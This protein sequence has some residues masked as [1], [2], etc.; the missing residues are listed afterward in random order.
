MLSSSQRKLGYRD[1]VFNRKTKLFYEQ[2]AGDNY[3]VVDFTGG[4]DS[5]EATAVTTADVLLSNPSTFSLPDESGLSTQK[6]LNEW[7]YAAVNTLDGGADVDLDGFAPTSW[8][9]ENYALKTEVPDAY[10]KTES[11]AK[12]AAKTDVYTK[13]EADALFVPT[14]IASLVELGE[15][16]EDYSI[17]RTSI[18][19][20][21]ARVRS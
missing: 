7:L 16:P 21:I 19:T 8:V 4:G 5:E 9:Q 17:L 20:N 13:A 3:E 15:E 18:Q 10:T 1:V 11:D 14:D 2:T 12:Y 6:E